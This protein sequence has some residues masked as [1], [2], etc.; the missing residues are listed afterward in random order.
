M[1]SLVMILGIV[2]T[3]SGWLA[4][5]ARTAQIN[6]P[7][8][9]GI[10]YFIDGDTIAVNMNSNVEKSVLLAWIRLKRTIQTHRCSVMGRK[11]QTIPK[12]A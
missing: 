9:Y 6:Q 10:N 4:K 2:V 1:I 5:D 12:L 3:E 7:G 11:H 8:L